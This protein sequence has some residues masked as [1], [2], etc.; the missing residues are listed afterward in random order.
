MEGC[1]KG[2]FCVELFWFTPLESLS[3]DVVW[4]G[5]FRGVF[6]NTPCKRISFGTDFQSPRS[7]WCEHVHLLLGPFSSLDLPPSLTVGIKSKH[8]QTASSML[9]NSTG[10]MVFPVDD[11]LK[12]FKHEGV[13]VRPQVITMTP[14]CALATRVV[15]MDTFM[16][17]RTDTGCGHASTVEAF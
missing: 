13:A 2:F 15:N 8:A 10:E 4:L 11:L 7:S 14:S 1:Q 9:R 12:N 6:K 3:D 17:P 16:R 5:V